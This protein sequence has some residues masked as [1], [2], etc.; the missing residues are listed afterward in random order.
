[1]LRQLIAGAAL[2][3]AMVAAHAQIKVGIILSTTGPAASLGIPEKNTVTLYPTS[4]GGQKLDFII[5]DDATDTTSARRHTEKLT[6]EDRVDVIIGSSTSPASLAMIEVAANSRT[7]MISLAAS[8]RLVLPMDDQKRWVFKMPYNDAISAE[9]ILS[10]MVKNGV[11]TLGFIGYAEAYGESWLQETIKGADKFKVKIVATER[12]NPKDTSVTAQVLK[13]MSA[14]PQAVLIVGAGTPAA[15]PHATLIERGYKGRIYQTGGVINNDFL[16]VGGKNVEGALIP[17]GPVVVVDELPDVNPAKKPGA[18]YKQKYEAAFGAGSTTTFGANAWDAMLVL[19]R[20]APEA[21][22]KAKPGTP[23][24]RAALR[25][26]IE[27]VKNLPATHGMIN[28]TPADH[29]GFDLNA[30]VMITVRGGK[31]AVAK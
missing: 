6:S 15:L 23:E 16:R 24:F 2:A 12:F 1:M 25:D 11:K 7:P 5:L 17:S 14:N 29:N 4:A 20:A 10:H 9:A 13:V 30:P 27:G 21:L 8:G 26:A 28:M 31:W 22:K 18:E 19:Q 3:A